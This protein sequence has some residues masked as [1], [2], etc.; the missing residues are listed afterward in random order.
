VILDANI[1]NSMGT[2]SNQ[3]PILVGR[4]SDFMLWESTIR[5]RALQESLSGT[6]QVRYQ[7]YQYLAFIGNRY[8]TA[9]SVINGTGLIVQPGF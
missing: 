8:P 1:P 9:L 7:A 5:L 3:A 4:F 2:G 6:L